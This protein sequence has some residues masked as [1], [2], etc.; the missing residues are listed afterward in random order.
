MDHLLI[1]L[2]RSAALQAAH[3]ASGS[4]WTK[5]NLASIGACTHSVSQL[6]HSS[7][8]L[9]CGAQPGTAR[10]KETTPLASPLCS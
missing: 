4:S 10:S 5:F 6:K 2:Q 9:I 3:G 8:L 1:K 7:I